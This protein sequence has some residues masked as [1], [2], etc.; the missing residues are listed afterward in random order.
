MHITHNVKIEARVNSRIEQHSLHQQTLTSCFRHWFI[1]TSF[2]LCSPQSTSAPV[3]CNRRSQ[4]LLRGFPP[5]RAPLPP[6]EFENLLHINYSRTEQN[7]TGV[8]NVPLN[9]RTFFSLLWMYPERGTAFLAPFGLRPTL[10]C[11]VYSQNSTKTRIL[12]RATYPKHRKRFTPRINTNK[13][14]SVQ[15]VQSVQPIQKHI[16][17][18]PNCGETWKHQ[19]IYTTIIHE[20]DRRKTW[21][22]CPLYC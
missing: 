9:N 2:H 14:L 13:R 10:F 3:S 19:V 5:L 22:L 4:G 21:H 15:S 20:R 12:F 8:F 7:K 11:A 18:E 16:S 6:V 1:P 17:I